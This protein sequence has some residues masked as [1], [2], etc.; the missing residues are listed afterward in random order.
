MKHW[1]ANLIGKPY[2]AGASGPDSYDCIGLVRHYF[3]SQHGV[4]L[5][6]YDI[7]TGSA[8]D[9]ARFTRATGWR[10]VDDDPEDQDIVLMIGPDGRHVGVIVQTSEALGILHATGNNQ[11][12]QVI[13]QPL[14][15]LFGYRN[16]EIWRRV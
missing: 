16:F 7:A 2:E 11:R 3:R 8:S 15:T 1:A 13:W 14:D 12:G 4:E 6:D 9:L 10:P 5:P